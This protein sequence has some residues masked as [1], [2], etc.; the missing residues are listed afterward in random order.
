MVPVP[1]SPA[2]SLH[3][4]PS[5]NLLTLLTSAAA[6]HLEPGL[7]SPY[8]CSQQLS[9]SHLPHLFIRQV[10]TP[11]PPLAPPDSSTLL[12]SLTGCS[13]PLTNPAAPLSSCTLS[14]AHRTTHLPHRSLHTPELALSLYLRSYLQKAAG[15][16]SADKKLGIYRIHGREKAGSRLKT[17][18]TMFEAE[19]IQVGFQ[20]QETKTGLKV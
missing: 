8:L 4:L 19:D 17:L 12:I 15:T 14:L 6:H 18:K 2:A 9:L 7:P 10:T 1:A 5:L 20:V 16:N 13:F 3:S 11:L